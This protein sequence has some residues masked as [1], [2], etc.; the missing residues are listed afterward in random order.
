MKIDELTEKVRE[1]RKELKQQETK[2]MVFKHKE[3][4]KRSQNLITKK[5]SF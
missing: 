5:A 1:Q 4:V 2:I 3:S